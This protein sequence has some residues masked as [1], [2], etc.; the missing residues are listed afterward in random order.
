[1][2][3]PLE[4]ALDAVDDEITDLRYWPRQ[5]LQEEAERC[6]DLIAS[7]GAMLWWSDELRRKQA[8]WAGKP[9]NGD[10]GAELHPDD[11][12]K[13]VARGLAILAL[14]PCGVEFGD[15]HFCDH[16]H[17]GGCERGTLSFDPTP[18]TGKV[19]ARGAV[20]TPRRLAE[21]IVADALEAVVYKP[22]PVQTADRDEWRLLSTDEI[23]SKRI[24]DIAVGTG[25]FPLAGCRYLT[26]RLM[27]HV[28]PNVV[29]FGLE[30]DVRALVISHCLYYTDIDPA[31][32][33]LCRVAMALMVPFHDIDVEIYRHSYCGDS[34]LGITS[35]D[36]LRWMHVAPEKGKKIHGMSQPVPDE[37]IAAKLGTV[38]RREGGSL[39]VQRIYY[40]PPEPTAAKP[41][42]PVEE[43][44]AGPTTVKHGYTVACIHGIARLAVHTAGAMASDWHERY[45]TAWSAIVEHLYSAEHWPPH[46]DLVRAGQLAVWDTISDVWHHHGYYKA[47]T[48][49]SAAGPGSSPAFQTYWWD[50]AGGV[51]KSFE[52]RLVERHAVPQIMAMLIPRHRKV[53]VA[54]AVHGDYQKAA[55]ALG[56]PYV[57]FKGYVASA[58][59]RFFELWHEGEAP[60]RIWG[61]D[62][63]AGTKAGTR[64]RG[65]TALEAAR[66][67]RGA[68]Q[69]RG[70][71]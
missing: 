58:R 61:V 20:F 50:I 70:V 23:L 18:D 65:G 21:Q 37:F 48:I 71:A 66:R 67:R 7:G 11:V 49:G 1:M 59:R 30:Q 57:T 62:R 46:H 26:A 25:A 17:P 16:G 44:D 55:E 34:L 54:L 35:L 31:S 45:D 29:I 4:T 24:A 33:A 43:V 6:A 38:A 27:E 12:V 28:P 19:L 13:A 32:L 69:A 8:K 41:K 10:F 3:T 68:A 36:Q 22:G 51:S 40:P 5:Q 56:M 15:L 64:R 63:R 52:R 53:I 47:K 39:M 42:L 9:L 14:R 60:S 2:A